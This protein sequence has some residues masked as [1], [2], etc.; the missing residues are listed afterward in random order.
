ML[1]LWERSARA[2]HCFLTERDITDL[3]P[4]VAQ[5]FEDTAVE[6][7]VTSSE[8]DLVVGFLAYTPGCIEGL[9]IDPL[10][11]RRGLGRF[12]VAHAQGLARGPLRLD[13]NEGNPGAIGF[14]RSQGFIVVGRSV[15][16]SEGRSFPVLH[17]E[18]PVEPSP[19]AT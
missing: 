11:H 7:F 6:W 4:Q 5:S 15:T 12:L 13:V 2:T 10:H 9:F 19:G 1:D 18:R 8:G 16:D 14:Y 17:M 3:R